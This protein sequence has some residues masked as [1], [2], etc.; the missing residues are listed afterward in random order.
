MAAIAAMERTPLDEKLTVYTDS[1]LLVS[2]MTSWL[3]GWKRNGWIKSDKKPVANL[4]LV[5]RLDELALS[6]ETP[7]VWTWGKA[8]TKGVDY[9]TCG[10]RIVDKMATDAM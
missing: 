6:F 1:K 7:I 2:T 10:N 9:V 8:H 4:D 5:K 3:A